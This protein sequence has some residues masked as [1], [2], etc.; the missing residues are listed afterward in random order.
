MNYLKN[1]NFI[2][3][4]TN[5]KLTIWKEEWNNNLKKNVGIVIIVNAK[6]IKTFGLPFRQ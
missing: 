3:P 1:T 2:K 4:V 6:K 5:F